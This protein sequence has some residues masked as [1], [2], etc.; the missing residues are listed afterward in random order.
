MTASVVVAAAIGLVGMALGRI[1]ATPP[2]ALAGAYLA[3]LG[4]G[5]WSVAADQLWQ[6]YPDESAIMV[7]WYHTHP[8]FGI[9]L[10]GMDQ[11]IHQNFFTQKWHI[12]LVL[13]P[14]AKSGGFFCWDRQHSRVS[15]Y[16]FPWPT[17][18][19]VW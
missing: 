4:T 16:G 13:D 9:F 18:A 7:G 6:R 14:I 15:R 5:A 19:S 10:S 2:A 8:G 17:W 1:G 3:G 12:A 11:F